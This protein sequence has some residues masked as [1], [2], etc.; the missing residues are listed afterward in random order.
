M[1][2][3]TTQQELIEI[4][5]QSLKSDVL[6]STPRT[7]EIRNHFFN[8]ILDN[9]DMYLSTKDYGLTEV[10]YQLLEEARESLTEEQLTTFFKRLINEPNFNTEYTIQGE[11]RTI[12]IPN[13]IKGK[14]I[15]IKFM[16]IS[17][18]GDKY[19]VDGSTKVTV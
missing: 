4:M 5:Y 10:R 3:E 7:L 6:K 19:Y 2:K 16:G 9:V 18:S 8:E 12:S 11:T 1:S 15:T 13:N 17:P 14:T